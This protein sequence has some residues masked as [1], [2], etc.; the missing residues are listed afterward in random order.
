MASL[1]NTQNVKALAKQY[2]EQVRG[3]EVKIGADF[4]REV[5]EV[6]DAVIFY[7]VAYQDDS[8]R[9]T[10]TTTSWG[11]R[12]KTAIQDAKREHS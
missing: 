3:E 2:G 11:A 9:K 5:G 8:K 6:L 7:M 1:I 12:Q 10:L 4:L